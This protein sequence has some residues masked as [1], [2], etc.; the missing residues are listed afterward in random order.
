MSAKEILMASSTLPPL[1]VSSSVSNTTN[2]TNTVTAPSGIQNGDLLVAFGVND[3]SNGLFSV[4]SGFIL[5]SLQTGASNAFF[6][7]IKTAV[8]EV[9]NYAFTWLGTTRN[10]VSVSVYRNATTVNTIGSVAYANSATGTAT[11]ITPTYEGILCAAFGLDRNSTIATPPAGMT[12]RVFSSSGP[13]LAIYDQDQDVA[14]TGSKSL[15]WSNS[16]ENCSVLFQVTNE[17]NIGPD[18]IASAKTQTGLTTSITIAKPT[19]TIEGDLMVAVAAAGDNDARTWTAPAGWT[20]VADQGVAP[21][22]GVFYK[23]AGASEGSSYAFQLSAT[24]RM[25]G[26]ILTYRN[27]SYNTISSFTTSDPLA[28]PSITATNSQSLLIAIGA[29]L[30]APVISTPSGMTDRVFESDATEP[31]YKVCDQ[32]AA[33]G[34]SGIRLMDAGGSD[35]G[36]IILSINPTRSL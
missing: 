12:Q 9:G 3:T 36:G 8:N 4:P 17:P 16:S 22:I 25:A 30:G 14:A 6:I 34:P 32:I 10:T 5:I 27:A 20:E 35:N 1:F 28:L 29:K 26:C 21:N 31:S 18:F 19:G 23:I 13:A 7:A 15:I 24:E 11:S 33:K 2:T